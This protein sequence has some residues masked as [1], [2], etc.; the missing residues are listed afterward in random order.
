[1]TQW[2]LGQIGSKASIVD[3]LKHSVTEERTAYGLYMS[4]A[5]SASKMG[6]FK[7]ADLWEHIAN[8]E[9]QHETEFS[10]RLAN[11]EIEEVIKRS[12]PLGKRPVRR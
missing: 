5:R 3:A 10:E 11:I 7:S 9:Q 4:R 2:N 1:M 8:E 12:N 6:D